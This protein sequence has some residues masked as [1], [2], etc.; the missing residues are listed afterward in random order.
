M[1]L[2]FLCQQIEHPLIYLYCLTLSLVVAYDRLLRYLLCFY[3][4]NLF[5]T[6]EEHLLEN[7]GDLHHFCTYLLEVVQTYGL[8]CFTFESFLNGGFSLLLVL[9]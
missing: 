7:F 1:S 3:L 2:I 6:L 4:L 5:Y 9:F 8:I